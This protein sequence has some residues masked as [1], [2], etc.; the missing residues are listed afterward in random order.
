MLYYGTIQRVFPPGS[1]ANLNSYQYEYSV[2]LTGDRSCQIPLN[3]VLVMDEFGA[4]DDYNDR[5]LSVGQKVCV[6]YFRNNPSQ[7]F[8]V[9][10]IRNSSIAA[11]SNAGRYWKRRFNR[12][13]EYIDRS[14]NWMVISDEGPNVQIN[15]ANI[16]IDDSSGDKITLDKDGQK[17]LIECNQLSIVVQGN[18]SVKIS[19]D[20][21]AEVTGKVDVK[22]DELQAKV[23]GKASIEAGAE[24]SVKASTI[25]LNGPGAGVL[26]Q[27]TQ[28]TCYVSG[29]PFQGS[30]TVKAGS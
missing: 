1:T 7:A 24:C 29:L 21:Q 30:K 25:N 6:M 13:E 17:I 26:T 23:S 15:T 18:A 10:C 14:G 5:I 27:L 2:L 8:I 22:C 12:V 4:G 3:H 19:G 11:D 28:P 20:L 16:I 9:G